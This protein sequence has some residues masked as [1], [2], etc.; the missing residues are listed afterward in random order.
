MENQTITK[1]DDNTIAVVKSV[2][3]EFKFTPEYLTEQRKNIVAQKE[4]DN[5]QRDLEIAEVDAYLAEME[6][7]NVVAKPAEVIETSVETPSE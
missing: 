5:A 3:V 7:L 6:K 1:L 4:R 2:P